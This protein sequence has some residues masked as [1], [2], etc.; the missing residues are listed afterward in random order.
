MELIVI[1]PG[2]CSVNLSVVIHVGLPTTPTHSSDLDTDSDLKGE[3]DGYKRTSLAAI[4][5]FT[6]GAAAH[7]TVPMVKNTRAVRQ[8]KSWRR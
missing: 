4:R 5:Q 6:L 2:A 8:L 1:R 7:P 3:K